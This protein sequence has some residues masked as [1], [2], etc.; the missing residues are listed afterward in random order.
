MVWFHVFIFLISSAA[1][2]FSGSFLV[3][4]LVKIA[5]YL[6][7][8]EFVV[9]FFIMSIIGALPNIFIGVNSALHKVPQLSFGDVV[10]GNMV[11]LTLAVALAILIGKVSLPAKSKMVQSSAFFTVVIAILPLILILDGRLGRIDGLILLFTFVFYSFWLFSKSDRFKKA[12]RETK[13]E[14]EEGKKIKFFVFLKNLLVVFF[15]LGFLLLGSQGIIISAK[16][17]SDALGVSLPFV[18]MLIV[19]LG[20][21]LPETYFAVVS[22]KKKQTWMILGDLM[23]SVIVCATLVLGLVALIYPI[24]VFDFS[25]FAIARIFLI[26]SAVIFLIAIRSGEEISKR[27][28]I[29]LLAIYLMF[30][31]SEVIFNFYL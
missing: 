19:G 7:W 20:N 10:G 26:I 2:A 4:G 1:I 22:A 30:L 18:G 12:Y 31:L 14:K 29:L 16:G 5:R 15:S 17:F 8:R 6:H 25:S 23:G 9:A 13:E 3:K 27:E 11:D 24:E 28:G 21:A